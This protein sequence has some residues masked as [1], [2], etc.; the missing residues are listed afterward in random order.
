[1]GYTKLPQIS[2]FAFFKN[3]LTIYSPGHFPKPYKP[4]EFAQGDLESIPFN[5]KIVEVLFGD[6][7]IEK[8]A[9]GF[10]RAFDYLKDSGVTYDYVDTGNG[11]RFTFYRNV[12]GVN[13][14]VKMTSGE[15]KV[16][17]ILKQN[18]NATIRMIS[19]VTKISIRTVQRILASLKEKELIIRMG[20]DKTG[21]WKVN[22]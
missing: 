13:G 3:R 15:E 2:K 6:E 16:Y 21:Y 14:V 22:K 10:G 11:F 18:P 17:D 5:P 8:Y 7:T 12:G 4:E 20:S 19:E 1:M 9:T